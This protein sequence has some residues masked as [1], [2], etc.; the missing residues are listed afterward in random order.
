[1]NRLQRI[2]VGVDLA[3]EGGALTA[4][5]LS[6]ARHA[7]WLAGH[8][9]ARV[10]FLHSTHWNPED[11]PRA[12][13]P[14]GASLPA[15][16]ESLVRGHAAKARGDWILEEERPWVA[17]TRRVLAGAND[18]VVLGKRNHT[19]RQ[20][21]K[22]GSVSLEMIRKCPAPVWVIKPG[23]D[24]DH[25]CILAATDLSPVGDRATEY[26][27]YLA[28]VAEC[29]LRVVHAWQRPMEL[30]IN[31]ARLGEEETARQE[32]AIARAAREHVR[33]LPAVAE[34]GERCEILLA[35][36]T[37]S[38]VIVEACH[39]TDPEIVVLG[40]ISRGGI[41]G[42]LTGNT[43]ERLLYRLDT[44]LLTVKPVDFV[45]PLEP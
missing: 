35:C 22:L 19:R 28:R 4:G 20:D 7:L 3:G 6:A 8:T 36:D 15:E 38:H 12:A 13:T 41:A 30:A 16:L 43:A 32:A 11:G 10:D 23:Q 37:P 17:M 18:L 26:G 14:P 25:R 21:R 24:V 2:L 39:R 34:L 29:D 31:A 1:V 40:T 27:A 33:A 9:G 5:S 45:C 44:S 42:L